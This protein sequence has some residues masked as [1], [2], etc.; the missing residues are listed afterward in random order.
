MS[1]KNVQ[2]LLSADVAVSGTVTL[3]Y[4]AGSVQADFDPAGA[5]LAGIAGAEL[6]S[7]G[8]DFSQ[9]FNANDVT[10]TNGA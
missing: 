4:P 6:T 1:S 10:F 8:S 2:F 9:T 5:H 3:P 7:A